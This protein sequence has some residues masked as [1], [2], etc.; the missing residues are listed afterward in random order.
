MKGHI[1]IAFVFLMAS[2]TAVA[3]VI[4]TVGAQVITWLPHGGVMDIGDKV[5]IREDRTDSLDIE[6]V[7]DPAGGG[8][9]LLSHHAV[10]H[11]GF[12]MS[13]YWLKFELENVSPDSLWLQLGHAFIPQATLYYK[14]ADGHWVAI[15]SGYTVPLAQK[16]VI[17][18]NQT[19]PL[20]AGRHLFFLRF[21][22][23]VNTIP[24]EIADNA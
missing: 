21:R 2:Q 6:E 15:Q 11:F 4:Q 23:Y 5:L 12:T 16:P 22:P 19:F 17:D 10:L 1:V 7:S 13:I 24:V 9:F 8:Q 18:H 20:P 3:Q 14:G